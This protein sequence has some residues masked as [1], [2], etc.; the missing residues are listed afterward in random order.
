[1]KQFDPEG[2][3]GMPHFTISGTFPSLNEYL[4]A[5]G[6]NPKAGGRL[7]RECMEAAGWAIRKGLRGWKAGGPIIIHYIF[8]EPNRKRDKDNVA[9]YTS[10]ITQD[11]LQKCGTIENDGWKEVENFTHDFYIDADNPRIE[12]YL[13]EIAD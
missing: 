10:K 7:K 8:Y 1:M 6:R 13:E 2:K 3:G 11:A 5:C 4:A 12:V 9:S